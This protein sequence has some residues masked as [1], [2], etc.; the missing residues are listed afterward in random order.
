VAAKEGNGDC[1]LEEEDDW[2]TKATVGCKWGM[3]A[4]WLFIPL[5]TSFHLLEIL[6]DRAHETRCALCG[7]HFLLVPAPVN[8][9]PR[10]QR[11]RAHGDAS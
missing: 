1:G 11:G 3:T 4:Q 2:F 10:L 8:A 9:L 7:F 6:G 5:I